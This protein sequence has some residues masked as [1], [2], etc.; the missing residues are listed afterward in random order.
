[1]DKMYK[2][3]G[4]QATEYLFKLGFNLDGP[5]SE[6][7]SEINFEYEYEDQ[8]DGNDFLIII[9]FYKN[10]SQVEIDLVINANLRDAAYCNTFFLSD[11]DEGF[12][13]FKKF[14]EEE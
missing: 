14:L 2:K 7:R 10:T 9:T 1:M 8:V 3:Y 5:P 4:D 11:W 13:R 6:S 12:G